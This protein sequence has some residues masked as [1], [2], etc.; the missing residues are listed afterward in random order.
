[1]RLCSRMRWPIS[2]LARTQA[3]AMSEPTHKTTKGTD[4]VKASSRSTDRLGSTWSVVSKIVDPLLRS[5]N[6]G[7]NNSFLVQ[8]ARKPP[9][10]CACGHDRV[11][12]WAIISTIP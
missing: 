8:V 7:G 3:D 10:G 9:P 2:S 12:A 5:R 6:L 1:M 4:A 11:P